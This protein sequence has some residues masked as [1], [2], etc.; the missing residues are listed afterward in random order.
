[1]G[2]AI[3]K[4]I[5]KES[6]KPERKLKWHDC[7]SLLGR[8]GFSDVKLQYAKRSGADLVCTFI[9]SSYKRTVVQETQKRCV[10]TC[11]VGTRQDRFN[12]IYDIFVFE[13]LKYILHWRKHILKVRAWELE[14]L[15]IMELAISQDILLK[16]LSACVLDIWLINKYFLSII[17]SYCAGDFTWLRFNSIQELHMNNVGMV[18]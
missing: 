9:A 13:S 8:E 10:M 1:M 12:C 16:R 11:S 2:R 15:V 14:N 18:I 3:S 17:Y 4:L 6:G 5:I 7:D